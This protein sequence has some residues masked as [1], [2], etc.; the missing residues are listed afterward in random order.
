MLNEHTYTGWHAEVARILAER[1]PL[2]TV[3][4]ETQLGGGINA[5]VVEC[6]ADR[7]V[8]VGDDALG[9]YT[10]A[11]WFDGE[12]EDEAEFPFADDMGTP[13]E[14]ADRAEPYIIQA[15]C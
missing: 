1:H 14:A 11:Q 2:A 13:Q 10:R 5:V 4:H 12:G 9:I 15:G 3:T 8:V 6:G 7:V